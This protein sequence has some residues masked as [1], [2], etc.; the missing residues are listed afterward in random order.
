MYV[1]GRLACYI[2]NLVALLLLLISS[3]PIAVA[4]AAF[5]FPLVD[6]MFIFYFTIYRSNSTSNLFIFILGL[7]RDLLQG[8]PIGLS[9]LIYLVL[10]FMIISISHQFR[11]GDFS[12]IWQVFALGMLITTVL[13]CAILYLLI[14]TP[15][16]A[17]DYAIMQLLVSVALYP[18]FHWLF[19]LVNILVPESLDHA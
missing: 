8:T 19:N 4:G 18:I 12:I 16:M 14:G 13:K 17:M 3:L 7:T 11:R 9:A 10:R 6:M 1:I 15:L 2:P 5:F